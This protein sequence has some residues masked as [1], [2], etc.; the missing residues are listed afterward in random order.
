M[1]IKLITQETL[2]DCGLACVAMVAGR[3]LEAVR[4]VAVKELGYPKDGPYT[5]T[6][7]NLFKL[8]KHFGIGH[9]KKA[10]FKTLAAMPSL[11]IMETRKMPSTGNSHLVVFE[12]TEDGDARVLDPGWWLKQ[13]VRRDWNRIK[14][15]TFVPIYLADEPEAKKAAGKKPVGKKV[16]A[17]VELQVDAQADDRPA[18]EEPMPTKPVRGS[19]KPK[20]KKAA[21][22]KSAA[23]GSKRLAVDSAQDGAHLQPAAVAQASDDAVAQNGPPVA[24]GMVAS[25]QEWGDAV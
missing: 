12:R 16:T 5:T 18:A 20:A 3:S 21:Q 17:A 4:K 10:P 23:V 22:E 25:A 14:L 2:T 9:G 19:K 15:D 11:A 24:D 7:E 8:L 1:S 6:H 13:Q